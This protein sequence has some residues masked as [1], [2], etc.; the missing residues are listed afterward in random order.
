MGFH[1]E[2]FLNVMLKI[3]LQMLHSL[4]RVILEMLSM[5]NEIYPQALLTMNENLERKMYFSHNF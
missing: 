1:F 2:L 4:E 5:L 3:S